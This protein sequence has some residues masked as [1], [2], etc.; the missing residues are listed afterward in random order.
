[1]TREVRALVS[2]CAQSQ[3][4]VILRERSESQDPPHAASHTHIVYYRIQYRLY[5]NVRKTLI[6]EE[7]EHAH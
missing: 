7:V 5:T 1:M 3:D 2:S 4:P 6:A